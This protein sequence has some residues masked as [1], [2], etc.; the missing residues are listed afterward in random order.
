[1][2][3]YSFGFFEESFPA[4]PLRGDIILRAVLKSTRESKVRGRESDL[5]IR[6][7]EKKGKLSVLTVK[8]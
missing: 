4:M 6:E 2:E 3:K 7:V 5:G 8:T 1:M